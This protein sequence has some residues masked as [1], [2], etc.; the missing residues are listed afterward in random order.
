MDDAVMLGKMLVDRAMFEAVEK[1][2]V[3]T[4]AKKNKDM[5]D[6][7]TKV[8][9]EHFLHKRQLNEFAI[10]IGMAI[11]QLGMM[12]EQKLEELENRNAN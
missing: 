8:Y 3:A 9:E 11:A 7:L 6:L 1:D 2:D 4:A 12:A 10:F 5:S